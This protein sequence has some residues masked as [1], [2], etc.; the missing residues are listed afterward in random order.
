MASCS[1]TSQ[2]PDERIAA[3]TLSHHD[4]ARRR[5]SPTNPASPA[6]SSASVPGSG[7]WAVTASGVSEIP[8]YTVP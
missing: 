7:T 3:A 4:Y 6:P 8:R 2:I 1:T 5:R